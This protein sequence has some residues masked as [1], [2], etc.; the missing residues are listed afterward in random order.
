[1]DPAMKLEFQNMLDEKFNSFK[2]Q[3]EQTQA[4]LRKL[5]SQP[6]FKW[7]KAGNEDQFIFTKEIEVTLDDMADGIQE[8]DVDKVQ[9]N[10]EK[11]KK[12][13]A[14]RQ[15][16]IKI[17]DQSPNGWTTVAIYQRNDLAENSD[18]EKRINRAENAAERKN[19]AAKKKKSERYQPYDASKS[20]KFGAKKNGTCFH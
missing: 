7:K 16:M 19:K 1:M 4:S 2:Q 13:V 9:R 15:K 20:W 11:C 8:D 17:A 14:E 10:L 5:S 12:L 6:S 3:N 18:D